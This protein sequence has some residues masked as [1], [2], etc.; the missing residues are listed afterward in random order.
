MTDDRRSNFSN[1]VH[2]T[3]NKKNTLVTYCINI[4]SK[5]ARQVKLQSFFYMKK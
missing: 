1:L 4:V 2:Y 5:S 3:K